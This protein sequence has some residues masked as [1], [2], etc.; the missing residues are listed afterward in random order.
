MNDF[1]LQDEIEDFFENLTRKSEISASDVIKNIFQ[2]IFKPKKQL[3]PSEWA[4][5]N[6]ILP[7]SEALS[8]SLDFSNA[9]FQVEPLDCFAKTGIVNEISFMMGSQVGKTFIALCAIG[10]LIDYEPSNIIIAQPTQSDTRVFLNTKVKP[11]FSLIQ[12]LQKK[13]ADRKSKTGANN[14]TLITHND[15]YHLILAWAGSAKTFRQRTA[16]VTIADEADGYPD[17]EEGDS[18]ALLRQRGASFDKEALHV[19]ISTPTMKGDSKIEAAFLR[20]DQRRFFV[21]CKKRQCRHEQILKWSGV[22]WDKNEKTG[23]HLPHTARYEC[24]KCGTPHNDSEKYKILQSGRW[25]AAAPFRGHASFHLSEIYSTLVSLETLVKKFLKAKYNNDLQTFINV[26]LAETFEETAAFVDPQ[27]LIDRAEAYPAPIPES[28]LFLTIGA[29][30][31]ENRIEAE[32]VGFCE[33]RRT[34]SIEYRV[35]YGDTLIESENS[36]SVWNDF[37]NWTQEKRTNQNGFE[38]KPKAV[39][40]DSGNISE[41]VY[42]FVFRNKSLKFF[43]VKGVG[44]WDKNILRE[45]RDD[46]FRLNSKRRIRRMIPLWLISV[47]EMKRRFYR[48]LK[49]EKSGAAGFCHFPDTRDSDYFKML[50]AERLMSRKRRNGRVF[51]EFVKIQDRNEALDCRIYALA[52]AEIARPNY[53]E[54]K[55]EIADFVANGKI[56]A[57]EKRFRLVSKNGKWIEEEIK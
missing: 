44:G 39:C 52:A 27:I 32:I 11:I 7:E 26:S 13:L 56:Q 8:G 15:V 31:Q 36:D 1:L 47:N 17:T 3:K 43:A 48:D 38:M 22:K 40:I 33:N 49:I 18:L 20:G 34:F 28:V 30:I 53:E 51:Q 4:I 55:R 12:S 29:D 2:Q 45:S 10:Y 6:I 37:L 35:F 42:N 25:I 41:V 24:E 54:I 19:Q 46:N 21:K 23:E 16:R 57:K 50:T 5:Q 9:P 14:Q